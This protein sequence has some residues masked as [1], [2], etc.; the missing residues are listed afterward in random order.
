MELHFERNLE[1]AGIE[2]KDQEWNMSDFLRKTGTRL[3]E[4]VVHEPVWKTVNL[5]ETSLSSFKR[6]LLRMSL[7]TFSFTNHVILAAGTDVSTV[8]VAL[9]LSFSEMNVFS[10]IIRGS[11]FGSTITCIKAN[12]IAVSNEGASAAT[13]Q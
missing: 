8:H 6:E 4:T 7:T 9:R 5:R 2:G 1:A 13:S 11:S 10:T 12:R 3:L